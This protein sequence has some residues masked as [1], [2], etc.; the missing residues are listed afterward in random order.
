M[1]SG[2][3]DAA[4]RIL[5]LTG[6]PRAGKTVLPSFVIKRCF[7]IWSNK[8]SAPV[9]YFFFK[10]TDSDKNSV[11]TITRSLIYQL[12]L[13]FPAGLSADVVSLKDGS[14]NDNALSN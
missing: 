13:L 9:L 14:G 5:W 3:N 8:S 6:V 10:M 12:Y 7:E 1:K 4:T 11:L 2:L